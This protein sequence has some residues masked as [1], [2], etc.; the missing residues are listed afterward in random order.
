MAILTFDGVTVTYGH[1]PVLDHVD[2]QLERNERV[3]LI[4]RN[5]AGK[6]TLLRVLT[7]AVQADDGQLW[8]R[9]TLRVSHLEQEIAD[10]TSG[11]VYETVA[12]GLGEL[13]TLLSAYHNAVAQTEQSRPG[14]MQTLSDLQQRIEVQDGWNLDQKVATA[15]SRLALPADKRFA[16][17]SGGTK[18]RTMLARALV[19]SPDLLLLDEPT[20]HMDIDAI[21][22]LE[23][24]LLA[25][26]GSLVFV[27]HDRTL[28]KSLAT[29]IIELDRGRLT[30]FSGDYANY[31]RRKD[32]ILA[33]EERAN[34]K[35]DKKL[36]EQ[37]SWIREGIKARRTRN[38]GRVRRL[39]A[40]REQKRQRLNRQGSAKLQVDD[41]EAS[42]K[43]VVDVRHV[44][45]SY[46]PHCILQDFSARIQRDERVGIIGP[47]GS[48]KSTLLRLLLGELE[49]DNGAG[50][51]V[52]GTRL[53]TAYFDQER[54]PLDPD[55]SVRDNISGG[56]DFIQVRGR[57]RHVIGYLRD[58]L[59]SPENIDTPVKTLSGGER[60]RLL[61][62]MCFT[63]PANL[64]VLDEPTNDL[65]VQTLELLENLLIDF[66]GTILLVSHD[67][68]FLDSV[69]TSTLVFEGPGRVNEYV[70]GYDD[71]LRQRPA[72]GRDS[73]PRKVRVPAGARKPTEVIGA[74][75]KLS[76]G[77]KRELEAL[78]QAIE[79][80]E[81]E[82]QALEGQT[83]SAE[84]YRQEKAEITA[85]LERLEKIRSRLE[86]AYKRWEQ[87]EDL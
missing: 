5:G 40:M 50:R 7:G 79:A 2:L 8:Q 31:E 85:K 74:K 49:P 10:T 42:G 36:A 53:Q 12:A 69:V 35:F 4:G 58:F 24:F 66:D 11:T 45:F 51:I 70:G 71:W 21:R 57:R 60:N 23:E 73:V 68:A 37:E 83:A 14:A 84:F 47:N 76:Y 75:R 29:R 34:A 20:N 77:E 13:G 9:D 62:A 52:F 48:G 27:T 44:T 18:R 80:L 43:L 39:L 78:P 56:S 19:S 28:L 59:F 25:F 1:V 17:C 32:D 86:V 54:K 33:A 46:G 22:W 65:D 41:S 55:K 26:Q 87:L 81:I 3:C 67:R 82:Q 61:L 64:L 72:G 16:E 30:S 6:S 38:E 15:L 63:R